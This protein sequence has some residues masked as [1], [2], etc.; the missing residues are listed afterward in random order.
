MK[1]QSLYKDRA[2]RASKNGRLRRGAPGNDGGHGD[3]MRRKHV[4]TGRLCNSGAIK[5][6]KSDEYQASLAKLPEGLP[7]TYRRI[8]LLTGHELRLIGFLLLRGAAM[9]LL[10][11]SSSRLAAAIG[12]QFPDDI[13]VKQVIFDQVDKCGPILTIRDEKASLVHQTAKDY[14]MRNDGEQDDILEITWIKEEVSS[15]GSTSRCLCYVQQ[16]RLLYQSNSMS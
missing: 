13:S 1:H 16:G 6:I 14:P 2:R 7:G 15:R 3:A 9:A 4:L 12:T 10:P 5:A 8:V 11:L